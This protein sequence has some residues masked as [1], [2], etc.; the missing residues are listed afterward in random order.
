M[1]EQQQNDGPPW[2]GVVAFTVLVVCATACVLGSV[3]MIFGR[4]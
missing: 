4:T 3:W 2:A 1:A